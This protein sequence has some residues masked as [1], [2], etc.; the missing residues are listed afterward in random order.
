MGRLKWDQDTERLYET[1]TDR[2][3]LYVW[4]DTSNAYGEGV[5]WNGLT[6]VTESPSGAEETA[7]WADNIKYLSIRSAEELGGTIEAY[8]YPDEFMECDG[9]KEVGS[10]TGI[11]IGQ[12][13]RKKFGFVYR[14][15]VGNDTKGNDYGCK[16]HIIYNC[17]VSPS[18]RAYATINDSPEAMTFSWEFTT[19]PTSGVFAFGSED[20]TEH[21]TSIVT[22]DVTNWSKA[23]RDALENLL[24][25]KDGTGTGSS[26]GATSPTLPNLTTLITNLKEYA[27]MTDT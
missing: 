13:G 25:G 15:V 16:Y 12:Q 20:A 17:T 5:A 24:F 21:K 19:T 7:I 14:T 27:A 11:V 18:E 22:V 6:A 3:A 4:D 23:G 26:T 10:S 1:G 9:S 8:M 2:G